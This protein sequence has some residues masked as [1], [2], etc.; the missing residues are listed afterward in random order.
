MG[1]FGPI[2]SLQS[3][4]T[5]T[6][7]IRKDQRKQIQQI[8]RS[9]HENPTL[10]RDLIRD[11]IKHVPDFQTVKVSPDSTEIQ[12]HLRSR[13]GMEVTYCFSLGVPIIIPSP[14]SI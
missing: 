10:A 4:S 13:E 14:E 1:T 3:E 8:V 5:P 11:Y 6:P 12:L 2:H 7:K 9:N